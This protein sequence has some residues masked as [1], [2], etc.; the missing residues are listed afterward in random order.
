MKF[1]ELK[2]RSIQFCIK[3]NYIGNKDL[4]PFGC[5]HDK[6]T[7][8]F[9]QR[10]SQQKRKNHINGIFD[11]RGNWSVD[12]DDIARVAKDY[13]QWLF[14]LA[15]PCYNER[16]LE[17]VDHVVTPKMNH[18]LIQPY[19]TE[20]VKRALFQMHPSK[21]P[22]LDGMSPFFFQ[23]YWHVVGGDVTNVVLSVLHSGH[24]L[25]KMNYTHIVLIPRKNELQYM[26]A[27][28]PISLE[29]VISRIVSKVLANRLKV[30]LPNVMS[31][32]QSVFVP[33][34]QITD[35]TTVTFEV[36]HRM[37]NKRKWKKW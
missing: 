6:N 8:F 29:N 34:R 12:E 20:E 2:I 24:F 5:K 4:D 37:R 33:G 32:A 22:G 26:S 18:H 13:F 14:T 30:I 23:K 16:V 3:M 27:F 21:S 15:R 17:A 28:C 10:A 11:N 36:L 35:N 1:E 7:K 19:T 9:H 25:K 31:D